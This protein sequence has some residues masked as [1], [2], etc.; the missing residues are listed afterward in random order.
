[1]KLIVD[2]GTD[3]SEISKI[4]GQKTQKTYLPANAELFGE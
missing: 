2:R 1:M 3:I 4:R